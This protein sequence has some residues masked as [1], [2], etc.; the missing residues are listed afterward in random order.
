MKS[1]VTCSS[2]RFRTQIR[3]FE[4]GLIESGIVVYSP[5]LHEGKEE[6]ATLS[7]DYK[8]YICAGLTHNHFQ[9][10]RM[11]DVVYVYN[12]G[13]YAGPS[14]TMELAY[15]V[16]CGKPI[17]AF[18]HDDEICRDVLFTGLAQTPDEL[19]EKALK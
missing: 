6:W 1:V 2:K 9:R 17:Y 4:K 7:E 15:A 12:E 19:I 14:V 10:I 3:A 11:A 5:P 8:R 16:A 18:A 13:G